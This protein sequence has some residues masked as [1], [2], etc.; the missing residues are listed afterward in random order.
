MTSVEYVKPPIEPES[1]KE[2]RDVR[3][4]PGGR[5]CRVQRVSGDRQK[6]LVEDDGRC[7]W[8]RMDTLVRDWY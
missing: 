5:G 2:G 6:V 8:V 4:R 1:V 3:R 7:Y